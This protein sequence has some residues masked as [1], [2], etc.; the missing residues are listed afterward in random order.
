MAEHQILPRVLTSDLPGMTRLIYFTVRE[1]VDESGVL[2]C[3]QDFI[4]KVAGVSRRTVIRHVEILE[5]AGHLIVHRAPRNSHVCNVYTLPDYTPPPAAA[6]P[7]AEAEIP[8]P[9]PPAD[10]PYPPDELPK[11]PGLTAAMILRL[12]AQYGFTRVSAIIA[13]AQAQHNLTNPPGFVVRAVQG[14]VGELDLDEYE[15]NIRF[16]H[17]P[18]MRYVSGENAAFVNY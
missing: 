12:V 10:D 7:P 16:R 2:Q 15:T 18:G 1:L 3:S 11:L 6:T 14:R 8:A 17:N 5:A 9:E 4:A 13:Y